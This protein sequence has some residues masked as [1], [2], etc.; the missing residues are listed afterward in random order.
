[1]FVSYKNIDGDSNVESY[2][3]GVD[4]IAVKFYKTS[5][6]YVYSYHSAGRENVET[7]KKFAVS[8]DGLN[9]YI[10]LNCRNLYER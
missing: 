2:E 7:M 8:G 9:A 5:K 4:Y 6:I 1:M 10:N 3:I